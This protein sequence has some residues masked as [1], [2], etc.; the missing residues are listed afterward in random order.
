MLRHE[1][2]EELRFLKSRKMQ[3]DR[4]GSLIL[5]KVERTHWRQFIGV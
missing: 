2:N 3:M 5:D 4:G 1:L